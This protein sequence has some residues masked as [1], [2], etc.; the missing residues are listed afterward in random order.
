M[1]DIYEG[2]PKIFID[3]EGMDWN[4]PGDG[5]QPEMEQ[6]VE[7]QALISLFTDE[8]W[9]GNFY[10]KNVDQ[11]IGS[12]Y[13]EKTKLPITLPNLEVIRKSSI[14]ALKNPIFGTVTSVVTA[15]KNNFIK[16]VMTV[17]PIGGGI[18]ELILTKN[19]INWKI[20]SEK[21]QG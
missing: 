16:N 7:N 15:P 2:D 19:G 1:I 18:D 21:G 13:S 14:K 17:S 20:Q 5:G 12:D 4:F 8:G 6:G 9:P 11:K 3:E 10:F